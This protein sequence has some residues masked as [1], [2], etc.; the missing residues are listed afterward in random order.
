ML[1]ILYILTTGPNVSLIRLM[2]IMQNPEYWNNT[3]RTETCNC[4]HKVVDINK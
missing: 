1:N 4:S 3:L 2:L